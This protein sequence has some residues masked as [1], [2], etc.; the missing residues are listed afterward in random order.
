VN[1]THFLEL[2][3]AVR[4]F[5]VPSIA[6]YAIKGMLELWDQYCE[7]VLDAPVLDVL[8]DRRW[9]RPS[10]TMLMRGR[11]VVSVEPREI[12]YTVEEIIEAMGRSKWLRRMRSAKSVENSLT[13]LR[14]KERVD[15]KGMGWYFKA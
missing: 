7:R 1:W 3:R 10:P 8:R 13:R 14:R 4:W 9:D 15:R 5:A 11:T 2:I 6:Y 12:P